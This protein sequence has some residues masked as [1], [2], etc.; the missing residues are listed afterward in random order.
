M[1]FPLSKN[2]SQKRKA[3]HTLTD[4]KAW[5]HSRVDSLWINN[6]DTLSSCRKLTVPWER[7]VNKYYPLYNM[8]GDINRGLD[9]VQK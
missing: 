9:K 1:P 4:S 5:V 8:M 2:S 6:Q 7:Y 3:A